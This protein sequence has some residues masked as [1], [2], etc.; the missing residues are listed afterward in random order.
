MDSE[1]KERAP[2]LKWRSVVGWEHAIECQGENLEYKPH[3]SEKR[4]G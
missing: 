4:M 1:L 2:S 3:V